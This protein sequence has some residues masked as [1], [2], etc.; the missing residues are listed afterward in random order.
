M[1][2]TF[3]R[4]KRFGEQNFRH[5][6][7]FSAF[8]SAEVLSDKVYPCP[9]FFGLTF[10]H[11]WLFPILFILINFFLF[12]LN[13]RRYTSSSLINWEKEAF[14]IKTKQRGTYLILRL[15]TLWNI[16]PQNATCCGMTCLPVSN[17]FP[18]Y[19]TWLVKYIHCYWN[20]PNIDFRQKP[21]KYIMCTV[22]GVIPILN[23]KLRFI[24]HIIQLQIQAYLSKTWHVL[25]LFCKLVQWFV[26]LEERYANYQIWG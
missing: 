3:R 25:D 12:W 7:K 13:F 15:M 6:A 16:T 11:I 24:S 4:T 21:S 10:H 8:L 14:L 1:N 26:E 18:H 17:I 2:K 19:S 5:E 22:R 9:I 23:L 20:S